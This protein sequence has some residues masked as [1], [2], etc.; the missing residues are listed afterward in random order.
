[1]RLL[2]KDIEEEVPDQG[3]GQGLQ[4]R[5]RAGGSPPG[6]PSV[7]M[8]EVSSTVQP[9]IPHKVP[10]VLGVGTGEGAQSVCFLRR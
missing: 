5:G 4:H 1:M 6:G 9:Q 7:G 2:S 3:E 10:E 8:M